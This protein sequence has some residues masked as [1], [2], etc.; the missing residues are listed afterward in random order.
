V[1]VCAFIALHVGLSERLLRK[2][3][4]WDVATLEERYPLAGQ[5]L[6][7]NTPP[8]SVALANQH[9]GS[10][11]WYGHRPTLRW[12]LLAAEALA[13]TVRELEATGATVYVA[14]EG[15]EVEM[16]DSRFAGVIDELQVDHVGRVHNVHFRR[17]SVDVR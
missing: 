6:N 5:W 3:S 2:S 7:V 15:A 14:L 4:V 1:I 13:P 11:R 9:S 17:L 12:D 10:L 16:F 8:G